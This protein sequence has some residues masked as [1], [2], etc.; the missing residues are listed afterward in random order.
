[1]SSRLGSSHGAVAGGLSLPGASA[2]P[3]R[4]AELLERIE[5]LRAYLLLMAQRKLGGALAVKVAP[6]DVVQDTLCIAV[7]KI[8]IFQGGDHTSARLAGWLERILD[9][10]IANVRHKYQGTG[11]RR[12]DREVAVIDVADTATSPSVAVGRA[13][14]IAALNAALKRLPENYR[15]VIIWRYWQ[16][17][18]YEAIASALG[19]ST[20]AARK[21]GARA[22]I[23]M[24]AIL[25]PGHAPF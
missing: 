10:E 9:H 3:S 17:M 5:G 4:Q 15:R 13:E 11:K 21:L 6:S 16:R 23:A 7:R 18:S 2:V 14:G 25:G 1:M 22:L 19:I 12:L 20:D 24:R 8:A